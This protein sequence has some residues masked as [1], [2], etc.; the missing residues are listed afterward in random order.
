[1]AFLSNT[2]RMLIPSSSLSLALLQTVA[3]LL[4]ALV[5]GATFG[6]WRGYNPAGWT[7]HAFVEVHQTAVRGLNA[8]LPGIAMASL[9]LTVLLALRSPE[10]GAVFGAYLLAIALTIAGGLVTRLANQPINAQVMTWSAAAPAADWAQLR[11]T[12]WFWHVVRTL[13]SM[14][15]LATLILAVLGDRAR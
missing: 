2:L 13:V 15:A 12:W 1:M 6:I 10:R 4:L 14:A 11:D 5:A 8:L 9:A 3:I 7:P